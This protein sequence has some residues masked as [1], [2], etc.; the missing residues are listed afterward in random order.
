[1]TVSIPIGRLIDRL[2]HY[3]F[4]LFVINVVAWGVIHTLPL[5]FGLIIRALFDALSGAAPAGLNPWTLVALLLS[6]NLSRIGFFGWGIWVYATLWHELTLLIRRNLLNWLMNARGSRRLPDSPGEAVTR[7][8]DDVDDVMALIESLVDAGGLL[9]FALAAVIIMAL[10]NPLVTAVITVPLVGMVLLTRALTPKI[11]QFRRRS[12]EATGRVTS[13]IGEMFTAVQAV[14]IAHK[15]EPVVAHFARLNET[16]RRAALKDSLL[17]ELLRSINTNMVNIAAGLIL[18]LAA[19][20]MRT[21]SFTVGDFALF[22]TFLPRLTGT[23]AFMGDMLAQIRR[24]G[25]AF[26][27]MQRL[28]TDAPVEKFVEHAPLHLHEADLPTLAQPA[29]APPLLEL[30]VTGLSYRY[31]DSDKGIADISLTLP[32]GSFTVVTGRIGAGKTTLVRTLLGLLPKDSGEIR[33]NG[34][35]VDDPASFLVPPRS[36][37]TS[38]V[39]RLFSETLRDNVSL[40]HEQGEAALWRAL[41]LAVMVPDVRLL[42]HGLDTLVGTRG[43]KLSGGQ[44]QRSAAARMFM[45]QA[46]LLVVDDLSSAL[47]VETERLLWEQ[48]AHMDVTCLVVSSRRAALTR[49]DRIIVL[50]EGRIAAQGTLSELLASSAEMR[51]LWATHGD[52][53]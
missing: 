22:L 27:R 21:G 4:G 43:V 39:P 33:W 49:A 12:R 8:R 44:V 34:A 37:Y 24:T 40:G 16:R 30:R 3:R 9:L 19:E 45:R 38:Q 1:M 41:D 53:G 50:S 26:E 46:E 2:I 51:R 36:A 35:L 25:V 11:R 52:N 42:E 10:I 5:L 32:R 23:M 47:D 14:K 31:P 18:L 15:E 13:F 17:T 29:S 28:L 6:V 48:L 20:Q 7:F